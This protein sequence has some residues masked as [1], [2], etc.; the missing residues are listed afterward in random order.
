MLLV[1]NLGEDADTVATI[2]GQLA[3]A[4]YGRRGIP[5]QWIERLAWSH[6]IETTAME[7]TTPAGWYL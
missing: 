1:A 7:L 2:T 4:I 5:A 6:Q 3:G